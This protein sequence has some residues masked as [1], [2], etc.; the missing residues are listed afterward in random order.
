MLIFPVIQSERTDYR[1]NL[2]NRLLRYSMDMHSLLRIFTLGLLWLYLPAFAG[3][4]SCG[5]KAGPDPAMSVRPVPL[6]E[7]QADARGLGDYNVR[8]YGAV[9]D[10]KAKDTA[11]IQGAIDRCTAEGGG[12][13]VFPAG[14]Y[15]SGTLYLRDNVVLYLAADAR[16][17]GSWDLEDYAAD[18]GE[19]FVESLY[20]K[21]CLL[22]ADHA[23]H[24]G[25]TGPGTIDGRGGH[26]P[27]KNTLK[28]QGIKVKEEPERPMLVRFY[29]CEDVRLNEV[30][31]KDSASWVCHV[32]ECK[33]VWIDGVR[34]HSLCNRNNDGFDLDGCENVFLS[35]C[36]LNCGDDAICPKSRHRVCRNMAV[37]NCIVR[38][39]RAP[40]KLGTASH[41]GFENITISNCVFYDSG[42]TGIK[43]T[44]V[45]GGF[46]RN[47]HISNIV[48]DQVPGPIFLCLGDRGWT[49]E[50]P[51]ENNTTTQMPPGHVGS[52]EHITIQNI[53]CTEPI[54]LAPKKIPDLGIVICGLPRH[55]IN[56][57]LLKDITVTFCGGGTEEDAR[58]E[59]PEKMRDYP[60]PI[61]FGMRPGY[62]GYIR[63]AKN[64]RLENMNFEYAKR[65]VRPALVCEDVQGLEIYGFRGQADPEAESLFRLVQCRDVCM[66]NCRSI[67][68][69]KTFLRV[70]G[71]ESSNILLKMNNLFRAEIPVKFGEGVNP[72]IVTLCK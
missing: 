30:L 57:A 14:T 52:L 25:S 62:G 55:F 2:D 43:L 16:I 15:L 58:R 56:H 72:D 37:T 45:D 49:Y 23:R 64:I 21:R 22:Y 9:G 65:D 50:E 53:R 33:N 47:I 51:R 28:A 10:G 59:V 61:N 6:E 7:C 69:V 40:V 18:I 29:Q 63:H 8:A 70:E 4:S 26:F 54:D 13:V 11:A 66:E 60:S 41:I 17:I 35:N 36:E 34:I 42:S 39:D 44:A 71:S 24:I 27:N 32:V 38:S 19:R 3:E 31:L 1:M 67:D 46:M 12:R 68:P 48:M 20:F 5:T